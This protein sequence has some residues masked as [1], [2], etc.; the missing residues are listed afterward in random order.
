MRWI[1]LWQTVFKESELVAKRC[2]DKNDEHCFLEHKL[3]VKSVIPNTTKQ[4][5]GDAK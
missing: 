5:D 2:D 4:P 1:R 3:S